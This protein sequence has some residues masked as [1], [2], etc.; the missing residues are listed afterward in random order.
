MDQLVLQDPIF[1]DDPVDLDQAVQTTWLLPEQQADGLFAFTVV[2]PDGAV[3]TYRDLPLDGLEQLHHEHRPTKLYRDGL[4]H[5]DILTND[6]NDVVFLGHENSVVQVMELP[7]HKLYVD[8]FGHYP[9]FLLHTPSGVEVFN[10]QDRL[11]EGFFRV[12]R[13]PDALQEFCLL[14]RMLSNGPAMIDEQGVLRLLRDSEQ[15]TLLRIYCWFRLAKHLFRRHQQANLGLFAQRGI[16]Y[17]VLDGPDPLSHETAAFLAAIDPDLPNL[18]GRLGRVQ[19]EHYPWQK[20][21]DI[22]DGPDTLFGIHRE[23]VLDQEWP[24]I[25][26]RVAGLKGQALFYCYTPK[27]DDHE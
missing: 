16:N 3:H 22:Y 19:Y 26:E 23:D 24:E 4:E 18:H 8:L 6:A 11:V 2:P 17:S 9:T 7:R 15:P 10:D 5:F 21:L 25:S 13:T 14:H 27:E 20:V 1:G 12:L